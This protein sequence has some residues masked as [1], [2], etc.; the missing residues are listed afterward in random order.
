MYNQDFA[1]ALVPENATFVLGDNR[2]NSSDS[3]MIGSVSED[4]IVGKVIK[5]KHQD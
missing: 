5:I 1:E 3:R 4:K 2:L